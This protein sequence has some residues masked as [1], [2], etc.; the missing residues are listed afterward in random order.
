[1]LPVPLQVPVA[2]TLQ[3]AGL[4]ALIAVIVALLVVT[5][6]FSAYTVVLRLRHEARRR[7]RA[8]LAGAWEGPVLR[9]LADPDLAP[10]VHG[11]V[12]ARYR[13]HFVQ[14]ALEYSRR[15]RGEERRTLRALARPYLA[16]L[17]GRASSR[18]A[19]VRV[20]A[21][22]TLGAL[23]LPGYEREVL[24]GLDDPSPV[25]AMVAARSLARAEFPEHA[26]PVLARLHRFDGWSPR[27]L[28]AMLAAMGP[29]IAGE[30][31]RGLADEG[32]PA[33]VRAVEA[34][35][36]RIQKDLGAADVAARLLGQ[37]QDPDLLIA[38]LRLL[39]V[40]GRPEH[41]AAVRAL[42]GSAHV[43]VRAYALHSLGT[44]GDEGDVPRLIEAM[45][46]PSPW[47]A[48]HAARG[49]RQAGA[50]QL[51]AHLAASDHPSALL[52]AQVMEEGR[53]A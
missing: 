43:M 22:Q 11:A 52:A 4:L 31:R 1:V 39:E 30:L 16:P 40:V 37:P 18:R 47:V 36:L 17:A 3:D 33:W 51:L 35:A 41:A 21:V 25:V 28:A 13:L 8:R 49:V 12:E 5:L 34:E 38:A 14:F 7:L 32:R 19:E 29:Q 9:A 27:F 42:C 20:R 44:L 23:G 2:P 46:D 15:V 26:A 45:E 24:A 48:I 50:E 53:V 10:Q 6:A